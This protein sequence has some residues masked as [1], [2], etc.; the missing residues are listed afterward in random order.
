[1]LDQTYKNWEMFLVDSGIL[2]KQGFFDYL[3]DP[4]VT[5]MPSGETPEM[6][7]CKN[8]ASWCFNNVLNSGKLTGELVMYYCDD[9]L[10]YKE[11]FEIFWT[12]Y[13]QHNREP[14]AMYASQ[15]IGIIGR[16]GTTKIIGKRIADRPAGRFCR[17][18]RLDC[19]VDNLQFCHTRTILNRLKGVR[20]NAEYH[21]EDRRDAWHAD[22][23]FFEQIGA[24]TTVH[25]I[26]KF[27]SMN[28]RTAE[29]ANLEYSD[30][31]LGRMLILMKEKIRGGW[32]MINR[33]R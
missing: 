5:V 3:V 7:K 11:A 21:S 14:Q 28:R 6:A 18:R 1:M 32:R 26:N 10:L 16:D 25:N 31:R 29:S 9:D 24:L 33:P 13:V 19:Q 17:G 15:D 12:Y 20:G 23:I 8:M 27:V 30:S 2:F 22:G 4:R